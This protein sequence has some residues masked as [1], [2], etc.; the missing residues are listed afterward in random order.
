[1]FPQA[2]ILPN[3]SHS[4]SNMDMIYLFYF[5][6]FDINLITH[7]KFIFSTNVYVICHLIL[8]M[9]FKQLT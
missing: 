6:N 5:L 8:L 4:L 3:M 2:I 7:T 9:W 1:M